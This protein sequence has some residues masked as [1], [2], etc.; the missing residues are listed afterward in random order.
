MIEIKDISGR[1]KLYTLPGKESARR[2]SLMTEDSVRLVF[3]LAE[4]ATLSIGDHIEVD[5][6]PYYLT[7]TAYPKYNPT[8]GGYDYDIR[9]DSHYYRWK[10]HILFYDR[11][12]N[13][14][15]SWSLTR[16]PEAHLGIIVSNL[17]SLGFTYNG[18]EYT[19]IVGSEVKAEAKPVTYDSTNIIDALTKIAEAWECEWWVVGENIYLGRLE[20]PGEPVTLEIGKEASTMSRTKSR[21]LYATRLYV[22][23][24]ERNIPDD[25]RGGEAGTVVEGIVKKRLMLPE[26]TPY[27]DVVEGQK[28]GEVVE[29]VVVLDDIYPR[30]TGVMSCVTE[31][32]IEEKDEGTSET[33]RF[34]V[35]R[36]KDAG[37]PFSEKYI[38]PGEE[39]KIVFESGTLSGMEF[40]VTFNPDGLNENNPEAQV[41][42]IV[43]NQD[44]GQ[45]PK[46]WLN[47]LTA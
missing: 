47:S 11:Q 23:G 24:G 34:T 13:R 30:I 16:S 15:V 19:A 31:K 7:E 20:L 18:K 38:L 5:G 37:L 29:T 9:F 25:Y 27:I 39:L 46:R 10:N 44:Y 42:E 35:Y 22:F 8:T 2:F 41:F 43:R 45:P 33:T 40:T 6:T 32:E 21:D 26:G 1:T 36:F 28:E 14:E 4:P 17:R 12:G 3:T